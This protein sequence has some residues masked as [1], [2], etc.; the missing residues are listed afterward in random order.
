MHRFTVLPVRE[1]AE[2]HYTSRKVAL[3][4]GNDFSAYIR[5]TTMLLDKTSEVNQEL[6]DNLS[7]HTDMLVKQ[8]AA[9]EHA[10]DH[11]QS[12]NKKAHVELD[13]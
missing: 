11:T 5:N 12:V 9:I 7:E 2:Y 10:Y 4:S 8:N 6:G 1:S 13:K 3:E